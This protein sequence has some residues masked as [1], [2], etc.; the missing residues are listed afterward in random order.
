MG[1]GGPDRVET[2]EKLLKKTR[3]LSYEEAVYMV[4]RELNVCRLVARHLLKTDSHWTYYQYNAGTTV[5]V[6]DRVYKTIPY[7]PK[8]IK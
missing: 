5:K 1:R 2:I 8:F 3:K 4:E 6:S 7:Q